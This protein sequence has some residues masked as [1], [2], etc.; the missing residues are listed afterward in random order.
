MG[1]F[2]NRLL[3]YRPHPFQTGLANGIL[4]STPV[5]LSSPK[6][7][8]TRQL[9]PRPIFSITSLMLEDCQRRMGVDGP[10][11]DAC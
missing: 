8:E 9:L 5:G 1:R 7:L 11:L 6:T 4:K 2:W 10:A 3:G